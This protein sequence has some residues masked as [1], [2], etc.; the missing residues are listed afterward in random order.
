MYRAGIAKSP[1]RKVTTGVL[2]T[3]IAEQARAEAVRIL[4][5]LVVASLL[6][7]GSR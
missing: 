6:L 7:T 5:A 2:G 3:F 1:T 4:E